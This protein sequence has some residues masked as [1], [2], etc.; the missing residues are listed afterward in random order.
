MCFPIC[1]KQY[2]LCFSLYPEDSETGS[3]QLVHWW[4]GECF[5]DDRNAATTMELALD[6]LS[7]L[8]S[9]CLDDVVQH[10][11]Y[12]EKSQV[13]LKMRTKHSLLYINSSK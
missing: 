13:T 10:T 6:Y 12:D 9:G 8:I 3:E 1:L 11:S 4:I 5:N 7:E 2:L